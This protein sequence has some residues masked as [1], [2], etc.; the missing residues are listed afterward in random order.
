MWVSPDCQQLSKPTTRLI[1]ELSIQAAHNASCSTKTVH[2]HVHTHFITYAHNST[3]ASGHSQRHWAGQR[4]LPNALPMRHSFNLTA[5]W[6]CALSSLW[7]HR[8]TVTML[9]IIFPHDVLSSVNGQ[10]CI[11]GTMTQFLCQ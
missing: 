10:I 9:K 1:E 2:V 11:S 6:I 7:K 5:T 4:I 8:L 3:Q